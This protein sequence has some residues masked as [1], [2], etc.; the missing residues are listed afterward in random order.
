MK[1]YFVTYRHE[2]PKARG[3]A[4][5]ETVMDCHPLKWRKLFLPYT[6]SGENQY[7]AIIFWAEI[8]KQQYEDYRA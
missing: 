1:Y 5:N 7:I 3:V 6:S 4:Y 2:I 8:T